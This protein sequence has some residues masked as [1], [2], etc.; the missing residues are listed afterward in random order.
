MRSGG[1]AAGRRLAL[2]RPTISAWII[3]AGI[4]GIVAWPVFFRLSATCGFILK[5]G[6]AILP[7]TLFVTRDT[8][9]RSKLN[10]Q[11]NNFIPLIVSSIAF[12]DRKKFSQATAIIVGWRRSH[13]GRNYGRGFRIRISHRKL[14]SGARQSE[15]R[16]E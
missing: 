2:A 15:P 5:H 10:F 12:G 14:K 13:N 16:I 6:R 9:T 4:I 3:A 8:V 1:V 11:L 7:S